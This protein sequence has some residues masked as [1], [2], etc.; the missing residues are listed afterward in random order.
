MSLKIHFLH[1]QLDFFP[2]NLDD[3]SDEHQDI[4]TMEERYQ[5]RWDSAMMGDYC[6]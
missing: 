2:G 3:V 1:S 5:R 6:W 4:R